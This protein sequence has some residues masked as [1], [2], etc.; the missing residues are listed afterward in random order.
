MFNRKKWSP[1]AKDIYFYLMLDFL[2]QDLKKKFHQMS[3]LQIGWE[4][5]TGVKTQEELQHT[6][7]RV[8]VP[9]SVSAL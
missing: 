5:K 9:R 3:P 4:M 2:L 7:T 1:C 6:P 8:S